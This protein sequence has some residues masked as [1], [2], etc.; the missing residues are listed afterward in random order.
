MPG[1][2]KRALPHG[3]LLDLPLTF[4]MKFGLRWPFL[5][6][7]PNEPRIASQFNVMGAVQAADGRTE[8]FTA[9]VR[10]APR[11]RT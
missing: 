5:P 1:T 7:T 10:H 4:R 11:G 3:H 6:T 9:E 8:P 2:T